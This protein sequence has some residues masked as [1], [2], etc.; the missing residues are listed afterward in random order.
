MAPH[1]LA[2]QLFLCD[3]WSQQATELQCPIFILDTYSFVLLLF[4]ALFMQFPTI[5]PLAL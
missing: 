5:P 3:V 4:Y 2:Q 1:L